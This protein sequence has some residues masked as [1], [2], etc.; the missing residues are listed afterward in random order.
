MNLNIPLSSPA[1]S[2]SWNAITGRNRI[3]AVAQ[4]Q[5]SDN[6]RLVERGQLTAAS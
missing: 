3:L 4:P 6:T 1:S 2:Y 5:I